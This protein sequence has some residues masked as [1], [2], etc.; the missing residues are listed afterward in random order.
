MM[1][2]LKKWFL[3]FSLLIATALFHS[4]VF[5]AWPDKPVKIIVPYPPGG[6]VDVAARIIAPELTTV[7]GQ[8]FVVENKAGA[9]GMIAGEFVARSAPDGYTLFMAANGPLLF[10][11]IILGKDVYKWNK[12]F[13][14]I[15]SVSYTPLILQV[16]PSLPV[17]TLAEFI[18]LA[19][20]EP[21]KLNM[22][23]PGAGTTNHLASELLQSLTGA[24][25]NTVHYK[26]NAPATADLLGG[27]VDFNFDQISVALPFIKEGKVRGLAVTSPK[28]IASIPDVPTFAEAGVPSMVAVTF[29]G[30]LAPKGTPNEV[31]ERLSDT[32]QKIL[33]QAVIK[34]KFEKLGAEARGSSPKA[35][36]AY[37]TEED[38]RW[39]P[40][41]K[42]ARIK[43]D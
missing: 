39:T 5:A 8:P 13:A 18:A 31:L 27:Q 30:L 28:R 16:K 41:I 15:S 10:S 40:I 34:E 26:G 14:P 9:G 2:L 1:T 7:F 25:W 36:T 33:Q 19:K 38:T 23:S 42:S 3:Q 22:A 6:N 12:D 29:T 21:N 43:A 4:L 11:P 24:Q 35:F 37:L 17:K 32:L 20:K